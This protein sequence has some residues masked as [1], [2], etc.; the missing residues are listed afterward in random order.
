VL[1]AFSVATRRMKCARTFVMLTRFL[2]AIAPRFSAKFGRK[3]H[4]RSSRRN[5]R[6]AF[7]SYRRHDVLL[8]SL[9]SLLA[10]KPGASPA[11]PEAA[12]ARRC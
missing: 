10:P 8:I 6:G 7:T 1:N 4:G 3:T 12:G 5:L 9:H 2:N 11:A